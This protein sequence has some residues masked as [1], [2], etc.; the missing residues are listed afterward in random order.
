M[1]MMMMLSPYVGARAC[2][3]PFH[4]V[5]SFS[6]V[7]VF[8]SVI[9]LSLFSFSIGIHHRHSYSTFAFV[10]HSSFTIFL[11]SSFLLHSFLLHPFLL[12]SFLLLLFYSILLSPIISCRTFSYVCRPN[13]FVNIS[14][15]CST[16]GTHLSTAHLDFIY[17]RMKW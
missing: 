1:M 16:V 7:Y 11:S 2:I 17:S 3:V 15:I 6:I 10:F 14:A 5:C 13:A 8:F 9:F 12:H 4:S